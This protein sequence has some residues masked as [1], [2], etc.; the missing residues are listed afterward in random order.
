M[1]F[2][3]GYT[4]FPTSDVFGLTK[5]CGEVGVVSPEADKSRWYSHYM[6]DWIN[7]WIPH[8]HDIYIDRI[9][10][11]KGTRWKLGVNVTLFLKPKFELAVS[12]EL[13]SAYQG[14]LSNCDEFNIS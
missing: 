2:S 13:N 6:L 1:Y 10:N 5:L 4:N 9:I 7:Y 14:Y 8:N 11:D 12:S 3:G